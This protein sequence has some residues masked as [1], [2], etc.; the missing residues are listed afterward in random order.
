MSE[1]FGPGHEGYEEIQEMT[2][3]QIE[4]LKNIQDKKEKEILKV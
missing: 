2:D 1:S 4:K 3:K